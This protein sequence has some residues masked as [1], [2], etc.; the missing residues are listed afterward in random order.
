[1]LRLIPERVEIGL[2]GLICHRWSVGTERIAYQ[3][4]IG[5]LLHWHFEVVVVGHSLP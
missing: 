4:C 1:M 2:A 5:F 3:S